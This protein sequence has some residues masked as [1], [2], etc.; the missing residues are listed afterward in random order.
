MLCS[1]HVKSMSKYFEAAAES[2][3]DFNRWAHHLR[4]LRFPKLAAV[5]CRATAGMAAEDAVEK[6][7]V[8]V[9]E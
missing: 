7:E 3:A 8:A 9:A 2:D 5:C 6:A 4:R 1:G